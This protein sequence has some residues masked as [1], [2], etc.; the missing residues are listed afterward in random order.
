[1]SRKT[2]RNLPSRSDSA[3]QQRSQYVQITYEAPLPPPRMLE[4]YERIMPGM[5]HRLVERMEQQTVHRMGLENKKMGADI[6]SER[7]GQIFAFILASLALIGSFYLIATGKD[8]PG[9]YIFITTFASLV[10]VFVVGK[11]NQSRDLAR[12]RKEMKQL[13]PQNPETSKRA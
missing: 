7:T 4:E 1:M 13:L 3:I 9:I 12:K 8:R 10:T 5:A 6:S 11:F 2:Q